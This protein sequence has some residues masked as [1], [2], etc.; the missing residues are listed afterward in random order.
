MVFRSIYSCGEG[1]VEWIFLYDIRNNKYK[2]M[3]VLKNINKG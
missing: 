1:V 3:Y 2:V